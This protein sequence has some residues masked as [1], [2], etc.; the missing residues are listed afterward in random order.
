MQDHSEAKPIS[1]EKF[2]AFLD[3]N[4]P[5]TELQAVAS[6]IDGNPDFTAIL[7]EVLNVDDAIN[8][9]NE[10]TDF[11]AGEALPDEENFVLPEIPAVEAEIVE[12]LPAEPD[13][14]TLTSAEQGNDTPSLAVAAPTE[15]M[16][17]VCMTQPKAFSEEINIPPASETADFPEFD[18]EF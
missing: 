2:A 6:A 14:P 8:P 13:T 4:L 1:I 3:G 10:T 9:L 18:G 7:G 12:V 5:E 16:P 15:E 11:F 17:E